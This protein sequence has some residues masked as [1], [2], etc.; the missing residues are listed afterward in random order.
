MVKRS[1]QIFRIDTGAEIFVLPVPPK[2]QKMHS[3]QTLV[4]ANG[5]LIKVYGHRQH[6]V[7]FGTKRI[8][9]VEQPIIGAD[10]IAH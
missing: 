4:D 5:T 2:M 6:T 9:D 7:D 1:G 8:A 3:I 10:F